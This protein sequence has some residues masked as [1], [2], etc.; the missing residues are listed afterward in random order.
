MKPIS[1]MYP[2]DPDLI[3]LLEDINVELEDRLDID[4]NDPPGPNWAMRLQQRVETTLAQ[5]K[6]RC[7]VG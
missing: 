3:E 5:L 1:S 6:R 7:I 4:G 2:T